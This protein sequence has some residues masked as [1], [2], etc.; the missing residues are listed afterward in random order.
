MRIFNSLI[1]LLR[2]IHAS[3]QNLADAI[4]AHTKVYER[5]QELEQNTPRLPI[6]LP[7]AI[8][9]YYET[10]QRERPSNRNW[11]WFERAIAFL[12]FGAAVALAVLTYNTL[13][14]VKRQA[15]S[16][17]KQV[18]L[19]RE[20]LRTS[21]ESFRID[22]RAWI[23]IEPIKPQLFRPADAT[24]GA[25]FR[26]EIYPK[27]VGKTVA[28]DIS[29]RANSMNSGLSIEN[30]AKQMRSAQ[31]MLQR[32]YLGD[33]NRIGKVLAP[34][35][36]STVPFRVSGQEPRYSRYD[37][38]IGRIDYTDAFSVKHWMTFCFFVINQ[39]GEL[40]NC[41]EGNDEDGNPEISPEPR[42]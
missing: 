23:E 4:R 25:T 37:F 9:A 11:K 6:N 29:M 21:I 16:V 13:R 39:R 8:T 32:E 24:F 36:V 26:Y 31:D 41:K 28:R 5:A 30:D 2:D 35:T 42:H 33:N 34:N 12:A 7:P 20:Q 27:N 40:V 10:E 19:M 15:D 17:Q 1:Q 22:E 3:N 38:I 14:Q 18:S